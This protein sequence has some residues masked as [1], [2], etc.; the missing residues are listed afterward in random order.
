[1][2]YLWD[3][4]GDDGFEKS[5]WLR[6]NT[7]ND[8]DDAIGK[9]YRSLCSIYYEVFNNGGCN[10]ALPFLQDHITRV[11]QSAVEHGVEMPTIVEFLVDEDQ[12]GDWAEVI[13]VDVLDKFARQ[14][15][16]KLYASLNPEIKLD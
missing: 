1:M 2:A 10:L 8:E 3:K 14:L 12:D 11:F 7:T 4:P 13:E 5:E 9:D 15:I 16:D 6:E